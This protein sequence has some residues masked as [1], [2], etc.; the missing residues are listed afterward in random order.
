M[1]G[2]EHAVAFIIVLIVALIIL[3]VLYWWITSAKGSGDITINMATLKQCCSDRSKWNCNVADIDSVTCDLPGN[4][5]MSLG[6]L[7]T[8]LHVNDDDLP[9]TC[10]CS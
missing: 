7:A 8:S 4:K 3:W 9:A 6:D 2:M 5:T 10:Y 1:K